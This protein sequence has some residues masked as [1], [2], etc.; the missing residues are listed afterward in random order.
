MAAI[1]CNKAVGLIAAYVADK[2]PVGAGA[3]FITLL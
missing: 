1:L 3:V 2:I